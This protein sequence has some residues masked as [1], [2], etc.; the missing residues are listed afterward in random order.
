M[1]VRAGDLQ[2]APSPTSVRVDRRQVLKLGATAMMFA[3]GATAMAGAPHAA[4]EGL[5]S[6]PVTLHDA[7]GTLKLQ[8]PAAKVAV[9]E[10][11]FEEDCLALGVK[12]LM[13]ADDQGFGQANPLPTQ[14]KGKMGHYRSLGARLSP[15]LE[16]LA[17]QPLDLIVVDQNEQQKNYHQFSAIDPTLVL[18][19]DDWADFYPNLHTIGAALG[20]S[21]KAAQVEAA[22]KKQFASAKKHLHQKLG[23]K[24]LAALVSVP[25]NTGFF[26]FSGNSIQAGVMKSLGFRYA[27]QDVPGQLTVNIPL[28]TIASLKPDVIFLAPVPQEPS[29]VT[30]TWKGNAL[31]DQLPAVQNNRVITENRSIWSVARGAISIPLMI[32]QTVAALASD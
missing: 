10:W 4:A 7:E 3:C 18:N 25:T 19:T 6:G 9:Q 28:A 20:K 16:V 27:Y 22:I 8:H 31:W 26:A 11:Q 30:D 13:V 2:I 14:L 1:R 15:N 32:N 5:S 21:A 12:P 17:S 29:L 24:T 23:G